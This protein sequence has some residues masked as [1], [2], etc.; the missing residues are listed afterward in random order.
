KYQL[1]IDDLQDYRKIKLTSLLT[2]TSIP[3]GTRLYNGS[4]TGFEV[5]S[6]G[7]V[8]Y[9]I[10]STQGNEDN[11][12]FEVYGDDFERIEFSSSDLHR[13]QNYFFRIYPLFD[14]QTT[15][16]ELFEVNNETTWKFD[17]TKSSFFSGSARSSDYELT[18]DFEEI[19]TEGNLIHYIITE[20][21]IGNST[22]PGGGAINATRSIK[23]T[24]NDFGMWYYSTSDDR[25]QYS[26]P[27]SNF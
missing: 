11:Q 3:K 2:E 8:W 16:A 27:L 7:W 1:M 23:I 4:S 10:N 19:L 24:E 12:E 20:T 21:A 22:G 18:W 17:V 5:M 25:S 9:K 6:D 26:I 13:F 15:Y 14:A